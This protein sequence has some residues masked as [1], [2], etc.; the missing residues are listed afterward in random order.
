MPISWYR[1]GI[2]LQSDGPEIFSGYF[3]VDEISHLVTNFYNSNDLTTDILVT[4]SG[5]HWG[6]DWV[7]TNRFTEEGTTIRSIPYLDATKSA[8]E[9]AFWYARGRTSMGHY[10][11]GWFEYQ[12]STYVITITPTTA[13]APLISNICFPAG[14]PVVTNQGKIS[15]EELQPYVHTIRNKTIVGITQTVT[16]DKNLVCFEKDAIGPNIPSEKTIISKNHCIFY[17]G[18]MIQAKNFVGES[19]HVYMVKYTGEVLYNVLMEEHDKM[20]VNNLICETL[21]PENGAAQVYRILQKFSPSEQ[22]AL[23]KACNKHIVKNN[24]YSSKA[25]VKNLNL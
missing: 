23:I 2:K 14:T 20:I 16:R 19:Q 7:F 1:M 9:W 11:G 25:D 18:K 17:K 8:T 5:D 22:Q 13:P 10:S 4:G 24:L 3:R 21:N 6:A 12:P 15:I